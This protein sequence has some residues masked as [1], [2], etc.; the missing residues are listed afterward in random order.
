MAALGTNSAAR[1]GSASATAISRTHLA[2]RPDGC[3]RGRISLSAAT[4]A[5]RGGT[6]AI[7][8]TRS[9]PM[10]DAAGGARRS[11]P[12]AGTFAF[13][14][15]FVRERCRAA[16]CAALH[17]RGNAAQAAPGR[18]RSLGDS[19]DPARW[20]SHRG[21]LPLQSLAQRRSAAGRCPDVRE[22]AC[23][24][25]GAGGRG[26]ADRGRTARSR[27]RPPRSWPSSGS[28]VSARD[29]RAITTSGFARL[30]ACSTASDAGPGRRLAG[31]PRRR[32]RACASEAD[33]I[34]VMAAAVLASCARLPPRHI[35]GVG[36]KTRFVRR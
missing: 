33:K 13:Q 18:R 12:N 16:H 21:D 10:S 2:A 35:L 32:Y 28:P 31:E 5:P 14:E 7:T 3:A 30:P 26:V 6:S 15:Y 11:T 27:G 4:A 24:R 36:G 20:R 23:R 19:L 9:L 17:Y 8:A 1:T 34:R 29:H 22:R 25:A